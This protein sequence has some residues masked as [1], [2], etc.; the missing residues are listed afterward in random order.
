LIDHNTTKRD[1]S[2]FVYLVSN[3]HPLKTED[4]DALPSMVFCTKTDPITGLETRPTSPWLTTL[5]RKS[6][7]ILSSFDRSFVLKLLSFSFAGG[8]P[9]PTLSVS[10]LLIVSTIQTNEMKQKMTLVFA[11]ED[12]EAPAGVGFSY[13]N[14]SSDYVTNDFQTANDNFDFLVWFFNNFPDLADNDFWIAGESYAGV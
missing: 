11:F 12:L 5:T 8:T 7:L 14:T 2:L 6:F 13:S 10:L 9:T 3:H 4:P 1:S